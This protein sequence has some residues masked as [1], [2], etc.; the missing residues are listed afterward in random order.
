MASFGKKILS[1]FVEVTD[2][3]KPV[4]KPEEVNQPSTTNAA[5][6]TP[7]PADNQK[8][9][10]YFEKLYHDANLP[11]PDY[12]EF[13]KMI[14]AMNSIPDERARFCAAFAGLQVQGLSKDKLLDTAAAYLEILDKDADS[15]LSTVD[16]AVQ[17]KVLGK[18]KAIEE[19]AARIQQLSE[20]I[21]DLQNKMAVLGNE[22]KENE[23]KLAD[24]TDG[25]KAALENMKSRIQADKEK[26]M[27]FIQ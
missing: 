27:S 16:A 22:V 25:Y 24:S 3:A 21:N 7:R 20:E 4:S 12:Y 15:F 9:R 14:E 23:Q 10:Q 6:G 26:I 5:A 18:R 19:K 13:S 2:A 8:F 17:E 11:G 1:A